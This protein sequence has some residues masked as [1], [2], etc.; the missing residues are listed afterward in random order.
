MKAIFVADLHSDT[1]QLDQLAQLIQ[2]KDVELLIIGGDLVEYASS[3]AAQLPFIEQALVPF[4]QT[5]SIPVWVIP[6]NIEWTGTAKVYEQL[7]GRSLI[8]L[9]S[10]KPTD[11]HGLKFF[12]YPYCNPTPF[13][14]KDF[15]KRDLQSDKHEP[16]TATFLSDEEGK[17]IKKDQNYLNTV[18]SIEEDLAQL[19]EP[20]IWIMHAPPYGTSLDVIK[21]GDHVGSKA[22]RKRIEH[23]QPMLTLHGHIHESPYM[24]HQ[25]IDRIGTTIS[26]NPGRGA[27]L[28]AV[29]LH[30]EEEKLRSAEH[31]IF[32]KVSFD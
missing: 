2:E 9:L 20:G 15:E 16:A 31:T 4:I 23:I 28:H 13:T 17:L 11:G 14:R 10:L 32:G 5:I 8:S 18:P 12:G 21:S 26:I 6:G 19:V 3:L 30:F 1:K 25:W 22:I 24:T 7:A 27:Q 29:L